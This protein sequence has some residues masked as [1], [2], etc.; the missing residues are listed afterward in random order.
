MS[1][2]SGLTFKLHPLVIVN[3]ADHHTRIKAQNGVGSTPRPSAPRVFGCVLGVQTGRTVEVFNSFELTFD[4]VL[5]CLDRTFLETK[6]DQCETS[7]MR[8]SFASLSPSALL[9][10]SEMFTNFR[11]LIPINLSYRGPLEIKF[12]SPN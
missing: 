10:F 11:V 4:P 8:R 6:Q 5:E 1:S 3:I 12:L 7:L 2:S 9:A